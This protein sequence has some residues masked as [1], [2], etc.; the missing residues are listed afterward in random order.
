MNDS[1]SIRRSL[2]SSDDDIIRGRLIDMNDELT[3]VIKEDDPIGSPAVALK[4]DVKRPGY[5]SHM[6]DCTCWKCKDLVSVGL[7]LKYFMLQAQCLIEQGE[8]G[9]GEKHWSALVEVTDDL[10]LQAQQTW[11]RDILKELPVSKKKNAR[12]QHEALLLD[13]S[14]MQAEYRLSVQGNTT[15]ASFTNQSPAS[16]TSVEYWLRQAEKLMG[17]TGSEELYHQR[18]DLGYL[19]GVPSLPWPRQSSEIEELCQG[20][21]RVKLSELNVPTPSTHVS[22]PVNT[23]RKPKLNQ[24]KKI[25]RAKPMVGV[26]KE[27]KTSGKTLHVSDDSPVM[28][29]GSLDSTDHKISPMSTQ[30]E[31]IQPGRRARK[32]SEIN[33]KAESKSVISA[34]EKRG[35]AVSLTGRAK[36]ISATEPVTIFNDENAAPL[37]LKKSSRRAQS[38]STVSQKRTTAA[39]ESRKSRE[40]DSASVTSK[41]AKNGRKISTNSQLDYSDVFEPSPAQKMSP[42]VKGAKDSSNRGDSLVKSPG[43]LNAHSPRVRTPVS[44]SSKKGKLLKDLESD[45]DNEE[46]LLTQRKT[47]KVARGKKTGTTSAKPKTSAKEKGASKSSTSNRTSDSSSL[48]SRIPK[49]VLHEVQNSPLLATPVSTSKST[50]SR[51]TNSAIPSRIGKSKA[52]ETEKGP[53]HSLFRKTLTKTLS[54]EVED[55]D[56][57]IFD[58]VA[59]SPEET[60]KS[61][62]RKP[63]TSKSTNPKA[64]AARS[65]LSL[66]AR[67]TE[68]QDLNTDEDV[69]TAR[70]HREEQ[71]GVTGVYDFDECADC[72]GENVDC[73]NGV[74]PSQNT[75]NN[76]NC[77]TKSKE[78]KTKEK[79]PA[80][81]KAKSTRTTGRGRL[82]RATTAVTEETRTRDR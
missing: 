64:A 15:H 76:K 20:I 13:L 65:K 36:I 37:A 52:S 3:D 23:H 70:K 42:L 33:Q 73:D 72:D 80:K 9:Q 5:W 40:T 78:A 68:A 32:S 45:S 55:H 48:S 18:A 46:M 38:S 44:C 26:K 39:K 61:K 43:L 1:S 16:G 35:R 8:V 25:N 6:T 7:D 27:R 54:M 29:I 10:V 17:G 75:V 4:R 41:S 71:S 81:A 67:R 22:T 14:L 19:D 49:H 82:T 34:P 66:K 21:G 69:E 74:V 59:S 12:P 60:V 50:S 2:N 63:T 30:G 57:S 28:E 47:G 62:R 51:L 11:S 53:V 24:V 79:K 56:E 58:F 77:T 31:L